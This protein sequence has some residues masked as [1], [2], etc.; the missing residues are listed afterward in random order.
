MRLRF[1]VFAIAVL[2]FPVLSSPAYA[3]IDMGTGSM[4]FQMLAAGFVGFLF[5]VKMY[6]FSIKAKA[7]R[8]L[9]RLTGKPVPPSVLP[10]AGPQNDADRNG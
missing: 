7:A 5:T 10:D 4:V 9:A 2:L 1:S 8:L 6:W 3:Y